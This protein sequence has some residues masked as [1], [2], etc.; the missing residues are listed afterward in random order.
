MATPFRMPAIRYQANCYFSFSNYS[1]T[2]EIKGD[3]R[4]V[5]YYK[6]GIH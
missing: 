5:A 1:F 3:F 6:V 4:P 2:K